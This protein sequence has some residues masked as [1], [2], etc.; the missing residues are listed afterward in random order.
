MTKTPWIMRLPQGVREQPAWIFIGLLLSLVGL[1]YA[2]GV[3]T[4]SISQVITTVGLRVWGSILFIAGLMV[5]MSVVRAKV[6]FEKFALRIMS[7]VLFCYVGW[8]VTAIDWKRAAMTV[9]LGLIVICSAEVRIAFLKLQ[10]Q[11]PTIQSIKIELPL[12]SDPDE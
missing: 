8:I 7:M 3:T 2:T 12:E 4:S 11:A 5:I 6:A 9:A 1:S 10:L